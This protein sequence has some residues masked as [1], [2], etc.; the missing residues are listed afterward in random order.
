MITLPL[1]TVSMVGSV[2]A[3]SHVTDYLVHPW[4]I[5]ASTPPR[6]IVPAAPR[7]GNGPTVKL[8]SAMA[9]PAPWLGGVAMSA[10][11]VNC[12]GS[13]REAVSRRRN[14]VPRGPRHAESITTPPPTA[15][16]LDASVPCGTQLL[17]R[18]EG[19][20]PTIFLPERH[21]VD[22]RLRVRQGQSVL[23]ATQVTTPPPPHVPTAPGRSFGKMVQL[24]GTMAWPVPQACSPTGNTDRPS[25]AFQTGTRTIAVSHL[26]NR[27]PRGPHHG[28]SAT[29]P[30]PVPRCPAVDVQT[31]AYTPLSASTTG[32][33]LVQ[34]CVLANRSFGNRVCAAANTQTSSMPM[35]SKGQQHNTPESGA[36]FASSL[37]TT[38]ASE[39]PST[40]QEPLLPFRTVSVSMRPAPRA[41]HQHRSPATH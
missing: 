37:A 38:S 23:R 4:A 25:S 6:P 27:G 30:P 12:D 2:D 15:I 10:L 40:R 24:H 14:H 19:A 39:P 22:L 41:Q 5:R 17:P 13:G 29:A 20:L 32:P 11:A 31:S 18:V 26:R 9:R 1:C 3:R 21:H 28:G 7:K 34:P 35:R 8:H 36:D 16:N 33:I